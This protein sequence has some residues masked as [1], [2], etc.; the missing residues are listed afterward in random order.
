MKMYVRVIRPALLYSLEQCALIWRKERIL[1]TTE[2]RMIRRIMGVSLRDKIRNDDEE[3]K[4]CVIIEKA[5]E[6]IPGW[7]GHLR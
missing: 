6:I 4:V 7:F 1:E 2:M 3:L 5:R